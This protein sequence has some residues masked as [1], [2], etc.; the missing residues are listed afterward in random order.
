MKIKSDFITN[1]SSMSC[2]VVVPD[3]FDTTKYYD[4]FLEHAVNCC[5]NEAKGIDQWTFENFINN[6]KKGIPHYPDEDYLD[7]GEP[8]Y[9]LLK[10]LGLVVRY[11]DGGLGDGITIIP[12]SYDDIQ[13]ALQKF[14]NAN[15]KTEDG[16]LGYEIRRD[17]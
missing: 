10:Q 17:S 9:D 14:T 16:E 13:N 6:L 2:I 4:K 5:G 12:V 3:E 8:V 11:L 15:G 1:S 7:L